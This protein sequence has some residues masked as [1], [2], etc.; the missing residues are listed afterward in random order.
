MGAED[1]LGRWPS[2]G[3]TGPGDSAGMR[4]QGPGLEHSRGWT[5]AV[6]CDK[7]LAGRCVH[8]W[9]AESA[10]AELHEG[11]ASKALAESQNSPG[12]GKT[13][14]LSA[15]SELGAP[16]PQ[17]P[18]LG[19]T[20]P[21]FPPP[22]PLE[23][24]PRWLCAIQPRAGESGQVS[25]HSSQTSGHGGR[26]LCTRLSSP[27]TPHCLCPLIQRGGVH[28]YETLCHTGLACCPL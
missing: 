4:T 22:R 3:G 25:S 5:A 26:A 1:R 14:R 21:G 18:H 17:C 16:G 8:I 24:L 28:P 2:R 9:T 12:P 7:G 23:F 13:E 6:G 27:L 19:A 20:V 11:G 10:P 15:D